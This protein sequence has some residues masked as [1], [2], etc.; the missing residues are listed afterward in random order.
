[1]RETLSSL[2]K[3]LEDQK[4]KTDAEY[5]FRLEMVAQKEF[6]EKENEDLKIRL[7]HADKVNLANIGLINFLK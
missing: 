7:A 3:E 4:R 6:F 1:M 5:R 2:K